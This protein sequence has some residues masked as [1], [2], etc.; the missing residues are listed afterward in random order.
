MNLLVL[1]FP[2]LAANP[3]LQQ[4]QDSGDVS[5]LRFH[6]VHLT[7]GNF[8]DG[9]LIK[10]T[11]N[12]VLL[13]IRSGE[14]GIRRD[15]IDRVEFIKMRD[16]WTPPER[17]TPPVKPKDPAVK[18]PADPAVK[19][20]KNP[21]A[22]KTPA[23]IRKRIDMM[24]F[25]LRTLPADAEKA[26]PVSELAVLGD[27]G[28][29]Y[30]ASRLP[31]MDVKLHPAYSSALINLKNTKV[32]P[33]MEGFLTHQSPLVRSVAVAV[34]GMLVPGESA[35]YLRSMLS[36]SDASVRGT[37]LGMISNV[38][39]VEWLE[40]LADLCADPQREVRTLAMGMATKLA[41]KHEQQDR[42]LRRLTGNL[43]DANEGIRADNAAGI[44]GVGKSEAWVH[45]TPILTDPEPKVR[46]AAAMALVQ[47]GTPDAGPDIVNAITTERER[48][49]RVPLAQCAVKLKIQKAIEP[50][51]NWLGDPDEDVRKL[52]EATLRGLTGQALGP[53]RQKWVEWYEK[54]NK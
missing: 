17:S 12:Q 51:I 19:D 25:R 2:I 54:V 24:V 3:F 35:R 21:V 22:D 46:A 47:I 42:L 38:T 28:A 18:D 16:R 50:L 23:E 11:P 15:L 14:M 32:V 27:E 26:F 52:A 6:R 10:D 43:R 29:L 20:P 8:I 48:W 1:A 9:Q 49:V 53:D 13:R 39:D 5:E 7:N 30:L 37:V 33:V 4:F 34:I 45:L 41:I 40:P 36:D 31:D 44:G